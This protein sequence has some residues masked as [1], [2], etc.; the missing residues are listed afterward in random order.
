[1]PVLRIT[2]WSVSTSLV[3]APC[4]HGMIVRLPPQTVTQTLPLPVLAEALPAE[5]RVIPHHGHQKWQH[6]AHTPF[7]QQIVGLNTPSAIQ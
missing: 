6:G 1:M 4:V 2:F 3:R 5:S 7:V